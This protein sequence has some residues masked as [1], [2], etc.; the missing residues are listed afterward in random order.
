MPGFDEG[1]KRGAKSGFGSGQV[2]DC[3]TWPHS[4]FFAMCKKCTIA[5]ATAEKYSIV[6]RL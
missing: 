4:P 5:W 3:K 1:L 6:K 2:Y